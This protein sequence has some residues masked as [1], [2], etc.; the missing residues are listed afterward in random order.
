M[1][2]ALQPPTLTIR[3]IRLDG[4]AVTLVAHGHA[5]H[6]RCP[7]CG[8][9][10]RT[11]HDRYQR[12]PLDLPWRGQPVRLLVTVRRFRCPTA[13]CDRLTFAE[14]FG[15]A[16]P[17]RAQRTAAAAH[18]LLQFGYIAG[19][20]AG[21]RLARAS[22]L[23]TSPDTLLRL[24]RHAAAPVPVRPRVLGID[25]LALRKG[26]TYATLFVDLATHQPID[27]VLGRDAAVVAQWLREHPGVEIIARD[28]AEAYAPGAR[29]GAPQAIQV[30]DRF[31]LVQNASAALDE[32][33]H[34][35]HRRIEIA[36][37]VTPAAAPD[38]KPAVEPRPPSARQQR[39]ATRRAA[40]V[41]R[42]EQV[43][44]LSAQGMSMRGIARAVGLHR[45]TVR[46]LLATPE[47]PRNQILHPRPGG[48][49]SPTLQPYV[50][51]LQDRWQQGCHTICQLY[52]ELVALGYPGSRSLL[53]QALQPWRP[54]RP[55]PRRGQG[56][57]RR[58]SLR[59]LCLRPPDQLRPEEHA[60]LD[61]AL[62]K[63]PELAQGYDL[64]Q[65]FRVLVATRD[66]AALDR[67][68]TD[69]HTSALPSFVTLATG[70]QRDRAAVDAALTLPW[71]TGMVEG[72]VHR[73]K[74]IKRQ[75]YGRA[76]LDLLRR[77]ILA[78]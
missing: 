25:D 54:P 24:L 11:V 57:A 30:A 22:G 2:P 43:R 23:P 41:G 48:L 5:A 16:L 58:L 68:L 33:L 13:R 73:V 6:G 62:A 28:R 70:I 39:Q 34:S 7:D 18:L 42:W 45:K 46:R 26:R 76:T 63:D 50:S 15:A 14:D 9:V 10:S 65:R 77:R 71:S 47:P 60:A 37:A 29:D 74:L 38:T 75:G 21:A 61:G 69:A 67:W 36:T 78:A 35:R 40:R 64:L 1:G 53:Y 3:S 32:L 20:E 31:H 59:W 51:Y 72:H 49:T 8:T 66:V 4:P 12:R 55:P 17:H 52:R 44:G 27:L 19:G 56:R